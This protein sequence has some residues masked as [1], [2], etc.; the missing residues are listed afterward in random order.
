MSLLQLPTL[1]SAWFTDLT[2]ALDSRSAP[3][4]LQLFVASS[5][6]PSSR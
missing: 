1:L 2:A 3:R 4:L 6:L 5:V